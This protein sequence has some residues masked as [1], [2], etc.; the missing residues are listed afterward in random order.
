MTPFEKAERNRVIASK[1]LA[2]IMA[3]SAWQQRIKS[4]RRAKQNMTV[5]ERIEWERILVLAMKKQHEHF[6]YEA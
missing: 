2:G 1:R 6:G 5:A 4:L 3:A